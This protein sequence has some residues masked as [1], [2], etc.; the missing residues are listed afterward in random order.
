MTGTATTMKGFSDFGKPTLGEYLKTNLISFFDWSFVDKG[1]FTNVLI[2]QSGAYGGTWHKLLPVM[3]QNAGATSTTTN[4]WEGPRNNWVWETG[5]SV[6]QQP[7]RVSGVYL[8]NV[9]QPLNNGNYVDYPNGRV[10]FDSGISINTNVTAEY[11]WRYINV[12]DASHLPW[13]RQVEYDSMQRGLLPDVYGSG[14]KGQI[15]QTRLQLPAIGVELVDRDYYPLQLGG[16]QY[17]KT[18][19]ILHVFAESDTDA[20]R[21]ADVLSFQ[22][23]KTILMFDIDRMAQSGVFP[24]DWRGGVVSGALMY[25]DL[26]KTNVEGGYLWNKLRFSDARIQRGKWI[27][28]NLYNIPVRLTTEVI[29]YNI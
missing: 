11:S 2:P 6:S 23:D 12:L 26:V 27:H 4:V 20:G 29:L 16:G 9:F 19:I 14:S 25:P 24:L 13:F 15:P 10:V 21:L 1:A 18:D 8:D 7:I 22:N 5:V 3:D 28:R 17:A